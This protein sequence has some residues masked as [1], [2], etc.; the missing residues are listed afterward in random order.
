MNYLDPSPILNHLS[1]LVLRLGV[2]GLVLGMVK[3][4]PSPHTHTVT[5]HLHFTRGLVKLQP[6]AQLLQLGRFHRGLQLQSRNTCL[7]LRVLF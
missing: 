1:Y 7:D 2:S 6:E 4:T 5:T 3:T